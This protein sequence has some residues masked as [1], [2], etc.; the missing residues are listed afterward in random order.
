MN[1]NNVDINDI[2]I[3]ELEK[4]I[5]DRGFF[6]R[7][8]CKK[9][10]IEKGISFDI[11]QINNSYSKKKGTLR[12]MHYQDYC[13]SGQKIVRCISG[14]I[15]DVVVDIRPN[16]DSFGRW[17]SEILSAENR[18]MIYIPRGFAHGFLTLTENTEILY[19]TSEIYNSDFD[20][21]FLYNDP[22]FKINWPFDPQIISNKDKNWELFIS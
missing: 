19:F 21:G 20:N 15:Y 17:H 22:K 9:K 4:K 7:L 2:F 18:K 10:F 6:S 5:D 1:F 13:H 8:F 12:G 3:I 11:N 16:S 14:E